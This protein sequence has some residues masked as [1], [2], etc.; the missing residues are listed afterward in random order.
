MSTITPKSKAGVALPPSDVD[1]RNY[2][3]DP[4]SGQFVDWDG[5]FMSK[6]MAPPAEATKEGTPTVYLGKPTGFGQTPEQKMAKGASAH[7]VGGMPGGVD[8][9]SPFY[10]R[11][12]GEAGGMAGGYQ[13]G[14][15]GDSPYMGSGA[16]TGARPPA[17]AGATAPAPE[18]V[19]PA[20]MSDMARPMP[21]AAELSPMVAQMQAKPAPAELPPAKVVSPTDAPAPMTGKMESP[22][23]DWEQAMH[24]LM[25]GKKQEHPVSESQRKWAFAAEER[26]E[27]PEGTGK[28]WSRRAKGKDLPESTGKMSGEAD[29]KG[30]G[31]GR[32][33]LDYDAKG[34]DDDTEKSESL[35]DLLKGLNQWAA[36]VKETLSKAKY[37][38]RKRVGGK[39]VYEYDKPKKGKGKK[40]SGGEGVVGTTASGKSIPTVPNK[41]A[42]LAK[43][44]T[45]ALQHARYGT[46]AP[47]ER[48]ASEK[49][50]ATIKRS[51]EAIKKHFQSYTQGWSKQDHEDA[52]GKLDRAKWDKQIDQNHRMTFN[53][54][55]A[56]HSDAYHNTQEKS[57]GGNA[58]E[59]GGEPE[60]YDLA[61]RV[62]RKGVYAF[63]HSERDAKL[64]DDY[65]YDYLCA[66]IEEA[67]EHEVREK[68]HQPLNAKD[69]LT[70]IARAIMAELV[71]T[72]PT[73]PNLMRACKKY[74]CSADTVAQML[75]EKGLHRPAADS[76]W[77]DDIQ[78]IMAMGGEAM[79]YSLDAA[80]PEQ[81][82]Y[83]RPGL[84]LTDPPPADASHMLKSD[85]VDP[86]AE[87][88]AREAARVRALWPETAPELAKANV[89]ADCPVHGGRD[90]SKAQQVWNPL[91]PCLCHGKP[92][93]YG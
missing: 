33:D 45:A 4:N 10:V 91:Q 80:M 62:L 40:Q 74:S 13:Q 50:H 58:L 63:R 12:E 3:G 73:N 68:Q 2:V 26:G 28:K 19:A 16:G 41:L 15:T 27:V 69:Q 78:S 54:V 49:A 31:H 88:Q 67:Y 77:T 7:V 82:P 61:G 90:F 32:P 84:A 44:A 89:S 83:A 37:K 38:S 81:D 22:W 47:A 53:Q 17:P 86:Y 23:I 5:E 79:A 59:K 65:L 20:M 6:G 18:G 36:E 21:F 42:T 34:D 92:N 64:P 56:L 66:F 52:M 24:G 51:N 48:A 93:A 87:I 25:H 11:A 76:D 29:N 55:I 43:E 60:L 70:T 46:L 39:W 14:I 85:Y 35:G 1:P 71:Q 9:Q 30:R 75:V 57:M 8:P 72:L